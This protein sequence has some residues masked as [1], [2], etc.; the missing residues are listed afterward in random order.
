MIKVKTFTAMGVV[1]SR[2]NLSA[3]TGANVA[4]TVVFINNHFRLEA[5]IQW[6]RNHVSKTVTAMGIVICR[7]DFSEGKLRF[8]PTKKVSCMQLSLGSFL[9]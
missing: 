9:G 2:G 5:R 1:G 4:D 3:F 8:W 7:P 6:G